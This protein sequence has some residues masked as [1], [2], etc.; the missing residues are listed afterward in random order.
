MYRFVV[1][2][3]LLFGLTSITAPVCYAKEK[4]ASVRGEVN[5]GKWKGLRLRNL[6]QGARLAIAV[7][8]NAEVGVLLMDQSA[9]RHLP[10]TKEALFQGK[11]SDR[12]TFSIIVPHTGHYYVVIDNRDGKTSRKFTIAIR[13][14]ASAS[15]QGLGHVDQELAKLS[16]TLGKAFIF[17]SLT[18]RAAKCGTANAFSGAKGVVICAEYAEKLLDTLD[19]KKKAADALMFILLH[20]VGHVLMRQWGY[21]FYNNEEVADEFAT[22]LMVMFGQEDRARA[23]AEYFAA[24]PTSTELEHKLAKDDRHPLSVQRARNILRWVDD[25]QLV[26]KWQPVLV[27]HMQT[28]FLERLQQQPTTWTSR[29]LVKQELATR[30]K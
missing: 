29:T 23:Q 25:P 11:T 14:A 3:L 7:S 12:I 27:P 8:T 19:N 24:L 21:P 5:A 9:Y 1:F 16:D 20:E 26:R 10:A 13:A 6:P 30:S 15:Q 18:I 22:V 17:D 28:A 2:L 4:S